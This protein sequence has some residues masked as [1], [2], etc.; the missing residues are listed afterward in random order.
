MTFRHSQ[1][2]NGTL[3][4]NRL[5]A[6]FLFLEPRI[7]SLKLDLVNGPLDDVF[8]EKEGD[9]FDYHPVI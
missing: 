9:P 6:C 3:K 7:A 4:L 5:N 1:H 2:K 8:V